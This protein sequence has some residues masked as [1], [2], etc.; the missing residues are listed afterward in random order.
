MDKNRIQLTVAIHPAGARNPCATGARICFWPTA[1]QFQL[2]YCDARR[3]ISNSN[4]CYGSR[5]ADGA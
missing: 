4:S 1:G 3:T 5:N 2:S